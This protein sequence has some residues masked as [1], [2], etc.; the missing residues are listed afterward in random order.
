M[1][2]FIYD[3]ACTA[4]ARPWPE[5][6]WDVNSSLCDPTAVHVTI[7][8]HAENS[9][10]LFVC[11]NPPGVRPDWR[12]SALAV[13]C[14]LDGAPLDGGNLHLVLRL[15]GGSKDGEVEEEVVEEDDEE[16]GDDGSSVRSR[17]P[18]DRDVTSNG[19]GQ[20]MSTNGTAVEAA[21]AI[22]AEAGGMDVDGYQYQHQRNGRNRLNL[23]HEPR[24]PGER[25]PGRS[26]SRREVDLDRIVMIDRIKGDRFVG[27]DEKPILQ[28]LARIIKYEQGGSVGVKVA[29]MARGGVK[30]ICSTPGE[31]DVILASPFWQSDAFGGGAVA[32]RPNA[33]KGEAKVFTID[34]KKLIVDNLGPS[35]TD[36][37]ILGVLRNFGAVRVTR[38]KGSH[39]HHHPRLVEFDSERAAT[40]ALECDV[41]MFCK[42]LV[43]R[44]PKTHRG[45]THC[46]NCQEL[47]H[48]ATW[49]RNQT[50]CSD[51]ATVG[52]RRGDANCPKKD[53]PNKVC[54]NCDNTTKPHP[55]GYKGC[56]AFLKLRRQQYDA[57]K[58]KPKTTMAPKAAP[59]VAPKS[60]PS[61]PEVT[62][63]PTQ[64][65]APTA[66][67]APTATT[68]PTSNG[69]TFADVVTQARQA[70]A[71]MAA[72]KR[73]APPPEAATVSTQPA[74]KRS[75]PQ[76]ATTTATQPAPVN[77][78]SFLA[79][80]T[81]PVSQPSTSSV[82]MATASSVN[83]KVMTENQ[84]CKLLYDLVQALVS[85]LSQSRSLG[86]NTDPTPMILSTFT[87][88]FKRFDFSNLNAPDQASAA[89]GQS[90]KAR[91]RRNKANRSN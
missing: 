73:S 12:R 64:Q 88:I 22:G 69:K 39:Q 66:P 71:K 83:D 41:I 90:R 7:G 87:A 47:G 40:E 3:N 16:D 56:P 50:R 23:P 24:Q 34:K 10:N 48:P 84:V 1:N 60:A 52:H 19:D 14:G 86:K 31:A 28:E 5:D 18:M 36:D 53:D 37:E 32:H 77:A 80:S 58:A 4:V 75:T 11:N 70:A 2:K 62:P 25:Q 91:R 61:R 81:K 82:P 65:E 49:C 30:V 59:K 8:V 68:A 42:K 63:T 74:P 78:A 89:N 67:T 76:S 27:R 6:A 15:R 20:G 79:S 43:F 44:Y 38:L 46:T 13:S 29:F 21:G 35:W 17:S 45:P 72:V 51:C 33:T 55:S 54:C 57:D 85:V 9:A 26:K